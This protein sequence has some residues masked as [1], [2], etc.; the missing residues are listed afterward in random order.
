M[1]AAVVAVVA[2]PVKLPTNVVAVTAPPTTIPP[3]IPTPPTTVNAPVCVVI[4][5]VSLVRTT[6]PV[7]NVP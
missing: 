6:L 3:P 5:P 1:F 7:L 4:E 2:V